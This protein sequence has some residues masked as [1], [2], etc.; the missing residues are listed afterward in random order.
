MSESA[1]SPRVIAAFDFDGTLLSGDS[2][3]PF[4]RRAGGWRGLATGALRVWWK[5]ALL[6]LGGVHRDKAKAALL[7]A[8]LAGQ[9]IDAMRRLADQYASDL[10]R[11]LRIDTRRCLE[12]HLGQGHDVVLV[13]AS[14]ALYLLP[15]AE[16]L[17][18][19]HTIATELTERDG[20]L[21]GEITEVNVRGPHKARLLAEWIG[22]GPHY[23][24]AYGDSAGDRELLAAADHAV[25]VARAEVALPPQNHR[26]D[27]QPT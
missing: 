26:S 5:L 20:T 25:W 16:R 7:A 4:L 3:L 21:T 23:L 1:A 6:P 2:L 8:T 22:N 13:S 10:L 11:R 19:H 17:G 14:P 27:R 18:I 12:W 9:P 15:L 24:Y